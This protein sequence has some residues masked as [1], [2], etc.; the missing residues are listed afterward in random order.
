MVM[1]ILP[2]K[3]TAMIKMIQTLIIALLIWPMINMTA[4]LVLGWFI[5]L[6]TAS[7]GISLGLLVSASARTEVSAISIV[8]LLLLPQLMLGGFIKLY[9]QLQ[10]Q[11]LQDNFADLMPIRWSF[12]ALSILEYEHL[13]SINEHVRSL[14]KISGISFP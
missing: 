14:D 3:M 4:S 8:P 10:E 11:G 12:E 5:L 1:A 6:L 2:V 7:C 13:Y 9:G